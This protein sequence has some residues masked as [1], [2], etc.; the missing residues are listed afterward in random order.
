MGTSAIWKHE[1]N[2]ITRTIRGSL[3]ICRAEKGGTR[4]GQ[5][6]GRIPMANLHLPLS[7]VRKHFKKYGVWQ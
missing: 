2:A 1:E 4:S 5:H 6:A 7:L 3:L